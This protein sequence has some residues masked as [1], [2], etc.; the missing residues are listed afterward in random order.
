MLMNY[1]DVTGRLWGYW[2]REGT[3]NSLG[4]W[5]NRKVSPGNC[6]NALSYDLLCGSFSGNSGCLHS[7]DMDIL[8][9]PSSFIHTLLLPFLSIHLS[10]TFRCLFFCI[11]LSFSLTLINGHV[12]TL[13][14]ST[15]HVHVVPFFSPI[16]CMECFLSLSLPLIK[17]YSCS[18]L[19]LQSIYLA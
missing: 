9:L 3:I 14:L 12:Y 5:E 6:W 13:T 8:S 1:L 19:L 2:S 4:K 10:N 18:L 17:I 11:F 16:M 15:Y 7:S